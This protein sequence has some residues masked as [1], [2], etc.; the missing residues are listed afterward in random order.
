VYILTAVRSAAVAFGFVDIKNAPRGGRWKA[1]RAIVLRDGAFGLAATLLMVAV[2][3]G[4]PIALSVAFAVTWAAMALIVAAF[5]VADAAAADM[6]SR[7]P[8]ARSAT[9]HRL[10]ARPV[11]Q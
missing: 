11:R 2:A 7:G 10:T 4:D 3:G 8:A 6:R 5:V 9:T 1:A